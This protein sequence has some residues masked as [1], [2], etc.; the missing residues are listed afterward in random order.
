M[1]LTMLHLA[2][3][4]ATLQLDDGGLY[5][6]VKRYDIYLNGQFWVHTDTVVTTLYYLWPDTAYRMEVRSGD[7]LLACLDFTTAH[8]SFTM[9]VR[10]FGAIGDG[11]HDDTAAIQAAINCCPRQGRVLIPAG[12]YH[13]LP[14]FLKS[15]IT[16]ELQYG[17]TLLLATDR[18]QFPILPGMVLSTD[19]TD[20]VNFGSWEGNPLDMYAALITGIDVEDVL[21]C[22]EGVLDGRAQ[23]SDWWVD[24]RIRRGAWR[25]RMFFIN[26]CDRVTLQGITVRNSPAWN[27]HPYFSTNLGF[28]NLSIEAPADSPNTDGFDPESCT[29]IRM[30]GTHFTVGDDCIAIKSGKIYMGSRYKTPCRDIEISHCL[31]EDG[32]GGVTVGSEMAGGVQDVT[33]HHCMMRHTDRGFRVKTRRGRGVQ[34]V[35]DNILFDHVVMD[36]VGTPLVVNALYFCDPDGKSDYVQSRDPQP[37]DERTPRIG[38]VAFRHVQANDVTCAAYILGLPEKPVEHVIMQDVTISCDPNASPMAPAMACGVEPCKQ[39]GIVAINVDDLSLENVT[40]TGTLGEDR[41]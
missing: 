9:D 37:V 11:E 17:A 24:Q 25:P 40:I 19:E 6:T 22:G 36:H 15:H 23:Q 8:E 28:Y 30:A 16:I 31:M 12:D 32:H 2:A 29:H 20:D 26:R 34:G 10:E 13:V 14:L 1:E 35:I 21:I 7:E 18:D 5:N 27:L 41:L 33:I 38:T 4:S 39:T 3:R